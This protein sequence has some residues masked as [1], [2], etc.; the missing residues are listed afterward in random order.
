MFMSSFDPLALAT[1][2]RVKLVGFVQ[3]VK[4]DFSTK[5]KFLVW[6][7]LAPTPNCREGTSNRIDC[8]L[9]HSVRSG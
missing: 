1:L 7:Y 2:A 6:S 8:I 9:I 3:G 4:G 5:P